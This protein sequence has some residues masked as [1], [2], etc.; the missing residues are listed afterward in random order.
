ML[1]FS[2]IGFGNFLKS[3]KLESNWDEASKTKPPKPD[4]CPHFDQHKKAPFIWF[5]KPNGVK[6]YVGG[7]GFFCDW[8]LTNFGDSIP[9]LKE[10]ITDGDAFKPA[11]KK[12]R[13]K[14]K[15]DQGLYTTWA[16]LEGSTSSPV[17]QSV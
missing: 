13:W 4:T 15:K 5:E 9:A 8:A 1:S 11:D 6:E 14:W 16:A 10:I 3:V 12:F 7:R 17:T 2:N